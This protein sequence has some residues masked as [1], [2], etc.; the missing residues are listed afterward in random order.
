VVTPS[1]VGTPD[2]N[3]RRT[4]DLR[5]VAAA[6]L[7]VRDGELRAV[8]Y[9]DQSDGREHIALVAGE[10]ADRE[11]VLVRVHSE[12]LTGDVFHSTRC[13]CGAQLDAAVGAI[14]AEGRGVVVYLRGHEG[15]G[16]VCRS[17]TRCCWSGC[18]SV[19]VDDAAED[20]GSSESVSGQVGHRRRVLLG[21]GR[22]LPSGLVRAMAVVVAGVGVEDVPGVGFVPDQQVV[23]RFAP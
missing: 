19:L 5:L 21:E 16:I 23:E 3:V 2:G 20:L 1:R 4:P 18:I 11:Q 9:L 8:G 7:P 15:R 14:V 10:V 6:R 13:E 22:E 12:C 17:E